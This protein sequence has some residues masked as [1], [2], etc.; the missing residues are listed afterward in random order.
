LE[1]EIIPDRLLSD[2]T[3]IKFLNKIRKING[4]G[5][6]MLHGPRY[7]RRT[8]QLGAINVPLI[9]K[10]GRFWLEIKEDEF[11]LENILKVCEELFPF[12]YQVSRKRFLKKEI[13]VGDTLTGGPPILRVVLTEDENEREKCFKIDTDFSEKESNGGNLD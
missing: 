12:G 8:I 13:S 3:A 2:S 4:I 6:I 11:V 1:I 10:V 9:I 5:E 7:E